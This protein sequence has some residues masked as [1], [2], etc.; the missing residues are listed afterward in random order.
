VIPDERL[1]CLSGSFGFIKQMLISGTC[2]RKDGKAMPCTY[3][4][5]YVYP[6]TGMN[7]LRGFNVR[8]KS[9]LVLLITAAIVIPQ[10]LR[11][12]VG[13]PVD[14]IRYT[15]SPAIKG[16]IWDK[17]LGISD[18]MFWGGRLGIDFGRLF[19]L[20]GYYLSSVDLKARLGEVGLTDTAG[21]LVAD[22]DI[23]AVRIGGDLLL[24][25]PAYRL[26]PFIK[27]GGGIIQLRPDSGDNVE[28]IVVSAGG[29]FEYVLNRRLR[30]K[31]WVEL[32]RFRLDR[33]LLAP[34]GISGGGYPLDSEADKGRNNFSIGLSFD[35]AL[36][37]GRFLLS[38]SERRIHPFSAVELEPYIGRLN[39]EDKSMD[40][41]A[42]AGVR[43]GG[44]F[45]PYVGWG[46]FY[47]HGMESEL[48]D[49]RPLQCYGG[50]A[51]FHLG[52]SSGPQPF[53][54]LGAGRIDFRSDFRDKQGNQRDD[55]TAFIVGAGVRAGLSSK[56]YMSLSARDY[57]FSEIELDRISG[58]NELT[59][60]WLISG[61]LVF[62]IGGRGRPSVGPEPIQPKPGAAPIAYESIKVD[63]VSQAV[64]PQ[65]EDSAGHI[66]ASVTDAKDVH[67][68][69]YVSERNVVI[70]VPLEGEVYIRYGAASRETGANQVLREV[71]MQDTVYEAAGAAPGI[72]R[73]EVDSLLN[74]FKAEFRIMLTEVVVADT[75][76]QEMPLDSGAVISATMDSRLA[77]MQGELDEVRRERNTLDS[78]LHLQTETELRK[79]DSLAE[80]KIQ[81]AIAEQVALALASRPKEEAA[82]L[83]ASELNAILGGLEGRLDTLML[84]R[85]R[86]D[87]ARIRDQVQLEVA[88]K[89]K[90]EEEFRR[91]MDEFMRRYGERDDRGSYPPA[92]IVTPPYQAQQPVQ[93]REPSTILVRPDTQ[94]VVIRDT[95]TGLEDT[96]AVAGYEI[97]PAPVSKKFSD[98]HPSAYSGFGLESPKQFILG[99]RLDL[100]PIVAE[101][102]RL[103]L[104]PELSF[105]FGGG[106]ISIM[107]AINGEYRIA[108]FDAG[109]YR[110]TPYVRLGFGVIGY[111][112]DIPDRETEGVLNLVYGLELDPIQSRLFQSMESPVL[113]IE[114]QIID[115]FDLNRLVLGLQWIP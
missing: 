19:S 111:G 7:V 32:N 106:G 10:Y 26:I 12:D 90:D 54:T 18:G 70:P 72:T 38:A 17:D 51:R 37:G 14:E 52:T 89:T 71:P 92:I 64:A 93:T 9:I 1:R 29:G 33:Y 2:I 36:S 63:S 16:I 91:E 80:E 101:K 42:V 6:L 20:E 21:V 3:R 60:N 113:F 84:Q 102:E 41:T 105:G 45:N 48:G 108:D 95:A 58:T 39:F 55:K 81:N 109:S 27:I 62:G 49:T 114:H 23:R 100:G 13:E 103:R 44:E 53:L 94:Y 79:R 61:A 85:V 77:A 25:W 31:A 47:W 30:A 115:L 78:L 34:G 110:L 96:A 66:E 59:H 67:A 68:R 74:A 43:L 82:G 73:N 28:Q 40:H 88:R 97:K 99:G 112:G 76:V 56:I 5:R 57:M 11:A 4:K 75:S 104:A 65:K 24:K 22:Q 69:S 46:A 98:L 50:E 86:V 87:S 83:S 107:A 8:F 15:L 35:Y